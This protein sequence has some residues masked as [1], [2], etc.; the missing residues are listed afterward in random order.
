MT[1]EENLATEQKKEEMY[2]AVQCPGYK[3]P[4][5]S[6]CLETE[7]RCLDQEHLKCSGSEE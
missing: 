3:Q 2:R 4:T 7:Q 1:P 6:D 5:F